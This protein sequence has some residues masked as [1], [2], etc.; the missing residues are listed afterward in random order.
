MAGYIETARLLDSTTLRAIVHAIRGDADRFDPPE[1]PDPA[2][3]GPVDRPF[4][5]IPDAA[6]RLS[7]LETRLRDREDRRSV[8]LTIYVQMTREVHDGIRGGRFADPDWMRRYLVTFANYYRRAFLAF[9]RGNLDAVPDPWRLAFGSAVDGQTLVVQD[10]FLGVNAHINHDLALALHDV[11]IDPNR[12]QK[13]ADH[14]AINGILARLVDVQQEVLERTYAA[15]VDDVDAIFG[16]FDESLTLRSMTEGRE[17]AWRVAVVLT[18]VGVAAA[19][20]VARWVLRATATGGG[21]FVLSPHLDPSVV[22][23][24][25]TVESEGIDTILE[26]VHEQVDGGS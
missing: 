23:T 6:D 21:F 8:F 18:D 2:L 17:Q 4:D 22:R 13:Y 12:D 9:E 25:R 20:S 1:T 19:R 14:R 24:L 16:R 10:A 11:G 3:V 26:R 5:S 15:G 7:R